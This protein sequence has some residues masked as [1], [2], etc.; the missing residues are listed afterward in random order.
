MDSSSEVAK[1]LPRRGSVVIKDSLTSDGSFLLAYLLR[2]AIQRQH[3]VSRLILLLRAIH[4]FRMYRNKTEYDRAQYVLFSL[5]A[6]A[7]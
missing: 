1:F 2:A 3:R 6:G 7:Y 4:E 5:I